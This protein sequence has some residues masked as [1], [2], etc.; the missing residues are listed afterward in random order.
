MTFTAVSNTVVLNSGQSSD[1]SVCVCVCVRAA[2]EHE[3][4]VASRLSD[5][6]VARLLAACLDREPRY[7]I[8][9]FPRHGDLVQYLRHH[10]PPGLPPGVPPVTPGDDSATENQL[11][12]MTSQRRRP[13]GNASVVLRSLSQ[14]LGFIV[15]RLP[16]NKI[17]FDRARRSPLLYYSGRASELGGI[18]NLVDRRR[19]SL[20]RS[21]RPPFSS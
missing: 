16:A 11:L 1:K 17:V 13:D 8:T 12:L 15:Y 6:N 7:V 19:S 3:L 9:E 20:S 5:V 18:V 21:E 10:A 4:C 2:F 14:M